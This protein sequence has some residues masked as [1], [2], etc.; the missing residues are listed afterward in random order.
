MSRT[1]FNHYFVPCPINLVLK[2]AHLARGCAPGVAAH[3]IHHRQGVASQEQRAHILHN[4]SSI[5]D[6][7]ILH[8]VIA[9]CCLTVYFVGLS[10]ELGCKR[11]VLMELDCYSIQVAPWLAALANRG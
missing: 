8:D 1:R 11:A 5:F 10:L 3:P 4:V 9:W 6:R 7:G 2:V